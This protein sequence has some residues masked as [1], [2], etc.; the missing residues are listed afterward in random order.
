MND[1]CGTDSLA[2]LSASV[3]RYAGAVADL[4]Q[5]SV[6]PARNASRSDAGGPSLR[7]A[8]FEDSLS[9]VAFA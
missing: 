7:V 8:G 6:T 1:A 4:A 2:A 3:P 5:Y 9:A